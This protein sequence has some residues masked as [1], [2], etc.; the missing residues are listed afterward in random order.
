MATL[1]RWKGRALLAA[2]AVLALWMGGMLLAVMK[3]DEA[4]VP[5]TLY[6]A[7]SREC[8]MR[9][10]EYLHHS[11]YRVRIRAEEDL[12][13]LRANYGIAST[14]SACHTAI[15][16]GYVVEGHVPADVI[17]RLLTERPALVGLAV[18]GMPVGSPGMEGEPSQPY[19]VLAVRG[20]G[21]IS[22]YA[23]R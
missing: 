13:E 14:L 3:K 19:D 15:V 11:G 8:C 21:E 10:A 22:V 16:E 6:A 23:S 12:A 4:A 17:R 5:I 9:W 18:P 20:D 7:S 2:G 1:E